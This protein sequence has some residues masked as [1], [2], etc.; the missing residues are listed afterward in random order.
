MKT[1]PDL[2]NEFY[3][4]P[5]VYKAKKQPKGL[6]RVGKKTEEWD[7]ARSE[8]KK[9]FEA[10]GTTICE[11]NYPKCW[12]KNALGFAHADKRRF[13]SVEDLH[14]VILCCNSCHAIIEA[15]PRGKMQLIVNKIIKE[16]GW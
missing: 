16:R 5:K 7:T 11:L 1:T 6:K 9:L 2:T 4:Q 12:K 3:P 15:M 10:N 14:T 8:L 13:L